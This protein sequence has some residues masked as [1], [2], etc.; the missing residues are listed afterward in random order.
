LKRTV[1]PLIP[2]GI[3]NRPKEGF[4]LPIFDWM[5]EKLKDYC[6]RM[7]SKQR[8]E[9]HGLLDTI[10]VED[11]LNRFYSGDNQYA[12]KVWNLTMFQ[13]WWENYFG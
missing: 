8:L 3:T 12:G 5:V 13:L 4:V 1:E 10:V 11:I 6:I 9:K 2:Q 7:L